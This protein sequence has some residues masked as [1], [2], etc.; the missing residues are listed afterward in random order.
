MQPK[1]SWFTDI[2]C[3]CVFLCPHQDARAWS[4]GAGTV[5][6]ATLHPSFT[7]PFS[8]LTLQPSHRHTIT[9]QLHSPV[10]RITL[11]TLTLQPSHCHTITRQ[12]H[13]PVPR[14]TIP[15]CTLQPS[16]R[17]TVTAWNAVHTITHP[18]Y[19]HPQWWRPIWSCSQYWISYWYIVH[20][21]GDFLSFLHLH[22]HVH[23]HVGLC[24]IYMYMYGCLQPRELWFIMYMY[25]QLF[26]LKLAVCLECFHLLCLALH[27]HASTMYML[28]QCT[29]SY[30]VHAPTMYMLLQCTC[31]YDVH[32]ATEHCI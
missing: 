23:V 8:L 26:S 27:V 17:H 6:R 13:S 10:P 4:G 5:V 28:L 2:L 24:V 18:P 30:N 20:A 16:H 1:E 25:I 29:C 11:P 14:I 32:A 9:R 19:S 7:P 22:V 31:S 21:L 12:L 3:V 15:T